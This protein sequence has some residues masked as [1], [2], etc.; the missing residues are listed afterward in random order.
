MGPSIEL[1]TFLWKNHALMIELCEHHAL[2]IAKKALYSPIII[3]CVVMPLAQQC[4]SGLAPSYDV[5]KRL[6]AR[7]SE[8]DFRP[9]LAALRYSK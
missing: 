8:K 7:S 2:Q 9:G 5:A 4:Y 3:A 6:R 1:A